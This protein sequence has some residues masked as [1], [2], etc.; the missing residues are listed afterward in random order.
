MLVHIMLSLLIPCLTFY[1]IYFF[2]TLVSKNV[3]LQ[4]TH[5]PQESLLAPDWRSIKGQ[6][7]APGSSIKQPSRKQFIDSTSLSDSKSTEASTSMSMDELCA[8]DSASVPST[9]RVAEAR[10]HSYCESMALL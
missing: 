7:L 10:Q 8:V 9:S 6:A 2:K 1:L 5:M 3:H 4:L